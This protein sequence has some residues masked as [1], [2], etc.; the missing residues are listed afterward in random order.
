MRSTAQPSI[1]M[2]DS[3]RESDRVV[4]LTVVLTVTTRI[5]T[6]TGSKGKAILV[7]DF[8]Q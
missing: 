5:C 2:R 1:P 4:T 3:A 8:K 6:S 7:G